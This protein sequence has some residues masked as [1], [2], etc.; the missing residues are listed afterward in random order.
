MKDLRSGRTWLS[1]L[2]TRCRFANPNRRIALVAH[3][4]PLAGGKRD[5]TEIENYSIIP[6]RPL[7]ANV[8]VEVPPRF[9]LCRVVF[10]P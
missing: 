3:P 6:S 9:R 8:L 10:S 1:S 7:P 4:L 2:L 5:W